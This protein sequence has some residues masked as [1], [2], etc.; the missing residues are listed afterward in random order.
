MMTEVSIASNANLDDPVDAEIAGYLN[1]KA[2]RSFFLFAGAGSGKTRSLVKALNH[3]RDTYGRDLALHG[4]RVGV[5]TYTNAACDEINR[6]ID[7]HPLFH[8]STIH[9]FAW[10]IIQGFHHD[11]REWLRTNLNAEIQQLREEE[12]KGRAGTKASITRQ[13]QIQS[14]SKRLARL[15]AIK[16]FTYNP[17]GENKEPNSLNHSEVIAI[18]AAFIS[19][20]PLM[21]WILVGRFP[22]LLIDESQDTNRHLVDAFFIAARE[23]ESRF[24]LGLIG[25]VMQRIYA[26]G[27]ER[28][29]DELPPTWGKPSKKLNH[30]CPTRIVQ[31]INRVREAVDTHTQEPRSDAINGHVRFFIRPASAANRK[32]IEDAARLKMAETTG[33]N[34]WRARDRCKILTLEHHMAAKRLG[35]EDFFTPLYEIDSW[36]TGLLDGTLPATRFFTQSI[37]PLVEAQKQGDKFAV[38]RIVRSNSP[39]I[40]PQALKEAQD[41]SLLLRQAQS[42]VEALL[43]LWGV[44]EPNCGDILCCVADHKLFDIPDLLNPVIDVL[45]TSGTSAD[46]DADDPVTEQMAA[47]LSVMRVP[48]A[49]VDLYRRY[50]SGLASFDTHQGVK[51]LEF[52]RVMVIMDDTEA[53]GFMFGYGKLLGEKAPT[54]TDLKNKSEGRDTSIDRTRRLFYVTCSRA[55][56]SLALMAYTENHAAVKKHLIDNGWFTEEEIDTGA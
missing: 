43:G 27:K 7:F 1:P 22:F 8:V 56:K 28:I 11:I 16:S 33:D 51:G 44:G 47:L 2:P 19:E 20:K 55:E 42:G 41:P 5:I 13:A 29:E 49:E 17:S 52:E 38:A 37:L 15:D 14:K 18:C 24:A 26:D 34:E 50:V 9:S 53:R 3:V 23:H 25:D 36:R 12:T 10:E 40:A 54:T 45:K 48:F 39:L 46:A 32:D 21:R 30:R 35:F 4:H 31:L 6:R